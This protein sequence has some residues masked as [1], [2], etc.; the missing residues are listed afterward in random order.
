MLKNIYPILK[1]IKISNFLN[2]IEKSLKNILLVI[3]K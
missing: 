1:E 2:N 3:F